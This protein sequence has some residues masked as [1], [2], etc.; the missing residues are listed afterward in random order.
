MHGT[1]EAERKRIGRAFKKGIFK[2][3]WGEKYKRLSSAYFSNNQHY[4]N[5]F[6]LEDVEEKLKSLADCLIQLYFVLILSLRQLALLV[7][8]TWIPTET[9]PLYLE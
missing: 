1:E 5:H 8:G 9:L 6:H 7:T 4:Q 2:E 3:N